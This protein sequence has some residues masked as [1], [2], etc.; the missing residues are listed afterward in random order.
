MLLRSFLMLLLI[1]STPVLYSQLIDLSIEL[2][3]ECY[4]YIRVYTNKEPISIFLWNQK[5]DTINRDLFVQEKIPVHHSSDSDLEEPVFIVEQFLDKLFKK[6]D[7]DRSTIYKDVYFPIL[8]ND[9]AIHFRDSFDLYTMKK[10]KIGAYQRPYKEKQSVRTICDDHPQLNE[11]I[12]AVN[13]YL[14]NNEYISSSND[15]FQGL[16]DYQREHKLPL[17]SL[18]ITTLLSMGMHITNLSRQEY[19]Y[20]TEGPDEQC[21]AGYYTE[22][23]VIIDT[24]PYSTYIYTG[25][26]R[27][28]LSFFDCTHEYK[29]HWRLY[30]SQSDTECIHENRAFKTLFKNSPEDFKKT[31]GHLE[32]QFLTNLDA[33]MEFYPMLCPDNVEYTLISYDAEDVLRRLGYEIDNEFGKVTRRSLYTYQYD[34][35]LPIGFFDKETVKT[36]GLNVTF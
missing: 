23:N 35:N 14:I 9:F 3:D 24:I 26:E 34:K 17:G 16:E 19:K 15:F 20:Y 11:I 36:L 18:D 13:T 33:K 25:D 7:P 1:F 32:K 29:V 4:E 21:Y 10:L 28:K 12:D 2:I 5:T 30:D 22:T 31:T 27:H 6:E 8:K